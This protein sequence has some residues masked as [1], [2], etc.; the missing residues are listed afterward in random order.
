LELCVRAI[1]AAVRGAPHSAVNRDQL[2]AN[3]GQPAAGVERGELARELLQAP[4]S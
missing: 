2:R 3:L 1:A 4:V